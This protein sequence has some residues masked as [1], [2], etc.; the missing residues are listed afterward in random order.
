MGYEKDI[1]HVLRHMFCVTCFAY[2]FE[3]PQLILN[4][5]RSGYLYFFTIHYYLLLSKNRRVDFSEE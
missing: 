2:E 4:H 5:P 3:L 1:S